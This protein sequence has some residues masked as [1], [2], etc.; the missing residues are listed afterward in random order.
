[1]ELHT[2]TGSAPILIDHAAILKSLNLNPNDPKTQALLLVCERYGLDPI[3][4]HAVL[5]QGALYVTRDGY[6]HIAHQSRQLDGIEVVETGETP[7]HWTAKVAVY[8][9][10][11]SRPF[12]YTGRYSKSDSNKKY[13]AEMAITRAEVMA[14][15]RAFDVT[16]ISAYDE[17]SW[18]TTP[19]V[20]AP[21]PQPRAVPAQIRRET[22][23]PFPMTPLPAAPE[24]AP[25]PAA[26]RRRPPPNAAAPAQAPAPAQA[27]PADDGEL[28]DQKVVNAILR[29]A[30]SV[31]E[32]GDPIES[33]Q[34]QVL[35]FGC[36]AGRTDNLEQMT[37]PE[38]DKLHQRVISARAGRLPSTYATRC[39]E[40]LAWSE[41]QNAG[42]VA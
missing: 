7:T 21:S 36:T 14:M 16:G 25:A 41:Q 3:L 5:I 24:S 35:T 2:D 6:L 42:A 28:V 18:D 12:V 33:M 10:D 15:R 27:E 4:K 9:K 22:G 37:A 11:M 17:M 34:L 40:W 26:T 39:D 13:G 8:R 30:T 38:A 29:L 23:E 31:D 32:E 1:M 20:P 19:P